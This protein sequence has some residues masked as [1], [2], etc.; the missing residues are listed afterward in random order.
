M[1]IL[2][3]RCADWGTGSMDKIKLKWQFFA[4]FLGFCALLLVVLWLFQTV[5]LTDMY[6]SIRKKEIDKAIALVEQ[7]IESPNLQTI[8]NELDSD[9][10]I[11]VMP[12]QEFDLPSR[13]GQNN[14][15]MMLETIT[16]TKEFTLS[17]GRTLSLTFYAMITPVDATVSTLQTQLYI[18]TGIMF[19]LSVILAFVI[20][21]KI[22]KPIEDINK[23]AKVLASGSYDTYFYGKGFLE[24]NELSDTLNVAAA[25]LSKVEALRRELMA[26][27]SHDLRT[28][29]A[30]IYSH[31]EMMHDFP[32]EITPEQTQVIMDETRRLNTLVNDMLDIS[33]LE[34]GMEKLNTSVFNITHSVKKITERV[35]ELTKK[36]GYLINFEYNVDAFINADEVKIIQVYYNLLVNA[37]NYSGENKTITV[38]QIISDD[39]VRIEVTD[40]GEGIEEGNLPYI[41]ERYYKVDKKHKRAVIGTGLGLSIV[42]K[43]MEMH[44]GSYGVESHVGQGSTFWISLKMQNQ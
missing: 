21:K 30:L 34:T 41:W 13:S 40:M 24:I 11:L 5:L 1:H 31:A 22:S 7:N 33:K 14:R 6:K 44:G 4:F 16:E 3:Q 32:D 25:E 29:L 20:S 39:A 23:S 8:L 10:E 28:P 17:D 36:D 26:N 18:I 19:I 9:K 43:I 37:I 42:K 2:L 27:V 38:R 35:A 15:G 12:S